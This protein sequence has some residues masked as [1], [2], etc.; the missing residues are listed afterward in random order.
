MAR[1]WSLFVGD[2][3]AGRQVL[4]E[5]ERDIMRKT[6]D[7]L[8]NR[9]QEIESRPYT[10]DVGLSQDMLRNIEERIMQQ[11]DALQSER[12]Y[13]IEQRINTLIDNQGK[14]IAID[15]TE[16]EKKVYEF[17][18]QFEAAIVETTT[19]LVKMNQGTSSENVEQII[20]HT[21]NLFTHPRLST[22]SLNHEFYERALA[23]S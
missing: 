4:A 3:S 11:V 12:S 6:I 14:D 2:I 9:L 5:Q 19:A 10:A 15:F 21:S 7:Q 22:S 18:E 1:K 20:T 16:L 23:V 17:R 8:F 13:Q